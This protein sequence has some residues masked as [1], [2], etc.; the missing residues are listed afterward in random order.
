MAPAALPASQHKTAWEILLQG[1]RVWEGRAVRVLLDA[2]VGFLL[3]NFG[4]RR[5]NYLSR[6]H[7]S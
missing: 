4:C 2:G 7:D 3:C 6:L 5:L 1:C